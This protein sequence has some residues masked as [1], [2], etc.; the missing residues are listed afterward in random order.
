MTP[1]QMQRRDFNFREP[2][3][4]VERFDQP[5]ECQTCRSCALQGATMPARVRRS[6]AAT[7]ASPREIDTR[8][9][10][11]RAVPGGDV[12]SRFVAEVMEAGGHAVPRTPVTPDGLWEASRG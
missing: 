11:P 10:S 2:P 3:L 4:W 12:S 1:T 8:T 6:A 5:G 9:R 7:M